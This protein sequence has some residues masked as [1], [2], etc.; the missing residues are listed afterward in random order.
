MKKTYQIA[1][2]PGDG[3]GREVM[4]ASLAVLEAIQKQIG[5]VFD[6]R[7]YPAG[8]QHYLDSGESLPEATL[9]ACRAADAI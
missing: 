7:T 5:V 9:A 3:I 4:S 6:T 2:L 1:V 8:A